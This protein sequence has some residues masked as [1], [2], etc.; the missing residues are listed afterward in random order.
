MKNKK[1]MLLLLCGLMSLSLCACKKE[2]VAEQPTAEE[3]PAQPTVNLSG[4]SAGQVLSMENLIDYANTLAGITDVTAVSCYTETESN[5]TEVTLQE[6]VHTITI[7]YSTSAG[8]NGEVSLVYEAGP[9]EIA[10]DETAT[11]EG[12]EEVEG[13]EGTDEVIE[14]VSIPVEGRITLSVTEGTTTMTEEEFTA[15]DA[16][17]AGTLVNVSDV[18]TTLSMYEPLTSMVEREVSNKFKVV[19]TSYEY[20]YDDTNYTAVI[21]YDVY[22]QDGIVYIEVSSVNSNDTLYYGL[23]LS[24][25]AAEDDELFNDE[26][27]L[28]FDSI[29][30]YYTYEFT[31]E[32]K[33][34]EETEED[35]DSEETTDEESA[36][37]TGEDLLDKK[38]TALVGPSY[39]DQHPELYIWPEND[40]KYSRWDYRI[41]DSTSFNS[42]IT[43]ADGTV[44]P[45]VQQQQD[46]G[47]SYDMSG[48]SFGG[49][50][51]NNNNGSINKADET[52]TEQ[53]EAYIIAGLRKFKISEYIGDSI[54]IDYEAS[55]EKSV[56]LMQNGSVFYVKSVPTEE[57]TR[58]ET[59]DYYG[60]NPTNMDIVLGEAVEIG[61]GNLKTTVQCR[62]IQFSDSTGATVERA[63]MYGINCNDSYLIVVGDSQP[64]R[65]ND[66][67]SKI[68]NNCIEPVELD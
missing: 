50:D 38:L 35:A 55:T 15:P 6:G 7:V 16:V 33:I 46:D 5:I 63:Y 17:E 56:K 28:A 23:I 65:G 18:G 31:Y 29:E 27:N 22:N 9:G 41:T 60:N 48:S 66:T 34:I 36:E 61:S 44:I 11:E 52:T 51:K 14:E 43:L 40:I 47:Y 8:E 19:G 3:Q 32:P 58:F 68:V 53:N 13:T 59:T 2:E 57:W 21:N 62:T 37:T 24:K 20:F 4:V 26:V 10:T 1:I 67:L 39:Q 54:T 12:A 25:E 30:N 42:N 45:E 64:T 49:D